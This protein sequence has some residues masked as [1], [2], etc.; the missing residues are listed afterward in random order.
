MRNKLTIKQKRAIIQLETAIYNLGMAGVK[1]CGMDDN[2]LYAT[3]DAI[4]NTPNAGNNYCCVADAYKFH[5]YNS[6]II[7][8][9]RTGIVYQDSGGW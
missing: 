5:E 2:I 7:G 3:D 6:E 1:I 4:K 9:I 8:H